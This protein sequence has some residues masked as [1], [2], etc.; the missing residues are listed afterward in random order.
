MRSLIKNI[1]GLTLFTSMAV[2]GAASA[3]L[4]GLLNGRSADLSGA[5]EKS[6][7][8]GAGF[9]EFDDVD[10]EHF[11]ARFNY[12]FNPTTVIYGD[13]G[14]STLDG[15]NEADGLTFGVG[16]FWQMD[17]IF[18]TSNFAIHASFHRFDLDFSGFDN[19]LKGNSIVVEG[20]FSGKEPINQAGTMYF[21]GSIGLNRQSVKVTQV[22]NATDTDTELTFSGGVVVET[23]SKAGEFYAGVFYVD[24]LGFGAGY[25]HFLK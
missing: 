7:E 19:G 23:Q 25:R 22:N 1:A 2:S 14:Q 18:T 9:G 12:K 13:V 17:G 15:G 6:F 24:D 21:N 20:V 4:F 10:Y 3:E 11:G 16:G 5:P 8:V